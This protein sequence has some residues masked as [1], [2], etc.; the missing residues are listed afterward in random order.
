MATEW[1]RL[2]RSR[3]LASPVGGKVAEG[4]EEVG[5]IDTATE[6]LRATESDPVSE[7]HPGGGSA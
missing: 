2:Q 3:R 4:R 5:G 1:G 6:K 7:D